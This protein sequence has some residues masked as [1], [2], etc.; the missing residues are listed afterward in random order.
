MLVDDVW[1]TIGSC[2]LHAFSLGDHSEMNASI[3]DAAVVRAFRRTLLAEHL[4]SETGELDD[5][6]AFRLYRKIAHEN[7]CRMQKDDHDWQGLAFALSPENY[8]TKPDPVPT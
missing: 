6:T 5:R 2:N 4:D 3:W 1:A 8:G 7:R